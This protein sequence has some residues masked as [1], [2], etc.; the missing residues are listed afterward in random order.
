MVLYPCSLYLKAEPHSFSFGFILLAITI[1]IFATII[2]QILFAIFSFIV[3]SEQLRLLQL[4][5]IS[6]F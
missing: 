5:Q 2:T 4:Y 1:F 6:L 3:A